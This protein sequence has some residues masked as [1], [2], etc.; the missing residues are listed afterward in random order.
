MLRVEIHRR[1]LRTHYGH[2]YEF[3]N[4]N[5][6]SET[7]NKNPEKSKIKNIWPVKKIDIKGKNKKIKTIFYKTDLKVKP[8]SKYTYNPYSQ[9]FKIE[10]TFSRGI[11]EG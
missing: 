9:L 2:Y 1:R 8:K 6:L 10:L 7:E 5:N 4:S 3:R 11:I